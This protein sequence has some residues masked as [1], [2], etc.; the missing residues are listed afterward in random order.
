MYRKIVS[1]LVKRKETP[2][3]ALM[4]AGARQVGKTYIIREFLKNEVGEDD[5]VEFNGNRGTIDNAKSFHDLLFRLSALP[6]KPLIK[7]KNSYFHKSLCP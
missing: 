7:G 3:K 5:F 2:N 1:K 4:V 6:N